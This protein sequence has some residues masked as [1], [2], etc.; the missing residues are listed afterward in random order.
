[1]FE[2]IIGLIT[3]HEVATSTG[4]ITLLILI[5]HFLDKRAIAP[6]LKGYSEQVGQNRAMQE[7]L[8]N[9]ATQTNKLTT[10]TENIKAKISDEYWDRQKQWEMRRDAIYDAWRTL[11][12]LETSLVELYSDFSIPLLD[13][14]ANKDSLLRKRR[15]ARE[16]FY[17]CFTKYLHAKDFAD[18]VVGNE[19]P[20]HLA[21]YFQEAGIIANKIINGDTG[22][23][24]SAR[25]K[26]L[27]DKSDVI[28]LEARK[29][30]N[31]R[32]AGCAVVS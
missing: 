30:L 10:I 13:N 32:N 2:W 17:L 8:D 19:L 28:R 12:E 16:Q 25:K 4:I 1:M 20:K 5:L 23:F 18:L 15:R 29:E 22:Y 24:T 11:R 21:A 7:N 6:F 14:E 9:L 3:N 31:I 27:S 26:E